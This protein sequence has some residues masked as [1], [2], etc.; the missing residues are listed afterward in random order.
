ML[1]ACVYVLHTSLAYMLHILQKNGPL[2]NERIFIAALNI[3]LSIL[4]HII[5]IIDDYGYMSKRAY[6]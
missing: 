4:H 5:S 2:E 3:N 1:L 6:L